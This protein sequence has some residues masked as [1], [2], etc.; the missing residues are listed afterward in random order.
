[1]RYGVEMGRTPLT[2]MLARFKKS[3]D[4]E[5]NSG[6]TTL[7]Q[8]GNLAYTTVAQGGG[9]QG[10][11]AGNYLSVVNGGRGINA[12]TIDVWIRPTDVTQGTVYGDW[13][14]TD[15]SKQVIRVYLNAGVISVD[16]RL[17][18]SS[19]KT[20]VS[21]TKIWPNRDTHVKVAFSWVNSSSSYIAIYLDGR[22]DNVTR[23]TGSLV[24]LANPV[25][26][27]LIGTLW[28]SGVA[29]AVSSYLYSGAIGEIRYNNDAYS[30][31]NLMLAEGDNPFGS[32]FEGISREKIAIVE[33]D[34]K[35]SL[36]CGTTAVTS[37]KWV[38][39]PNANEFSQPSPL[40]EAWTGDDASA[41]E[42]REILD[43]GRTFNTASP[44]PV[45]TSTRYGTYENIGGNTSAFKAS[46][47][48]TLGFAAS[49]G[50]TT[51]QAIQATFRK[52]YATTPT[53]F[54]D[55]FIE[56][57]IKDA[58]SITRQVS[59]VMKPESTGQVGDTVLFNSD[60][61]FDKYLREVF[62]TT[63]NQN[64]YT[65]V[66]FVN[67]RFRVK[68][69]GPQLALDSWKQVF[70]GI[71]ERPELTTDTLTI[72]ASEDRVDEFDGD[73]PVKVASLGSY[74]NVD[75]K[76]QDKHF[77]IAIGPGHKQITGL[78]IDKINRIV[79]FSDCGMLAI[80]NV[81]KNGSTTAIP[82]TGYTV[83]LPSGNITLT[84]SNWTAGA[85][86][87]A[88]VDGLPSSTPQPPDILYF[89]LRYYGGVTNKRID[90][91]FLVDDAGEPQAGVC[92][93]FLADQSTKS[94]TRDLFA[95]CRNQRLFFTYQ[96]GLG[97]WQCRKIRS[98]DTDPIEATF[99]DVDFIAY[100]PALIDDML[101]ATAEAYGLDYHNPPS[102]NV[103]VWNITYWNS[104]V[105]YGLSHKVTVCDQ[106]KPALSAYP[107][108]LQNLLLKLSPLGLESPVNTFEFTLPIKALD[109][110]PASRITLA[111]TRGID[112]NGA[113]TGTWRILSL[114]LDP[115]TWSVKG[116]AV[117]ESAF[118]ALGW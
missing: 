30:N 37:G 99:R 48:L 109:L 21:M 41:A 46:T 78:N 3:L 69:G 91:T 108:N 86:Y 43:V 79:N 22:L 66:V 40:Y 16:V 77:N 111:R 80:T 117:D 33:L 18:S 9:I 34:L 105:K 20:L 7:S 90:S 116:L 47:S 107:G 36:L 29:S 88:D 42:A 56:G 59:F 65:G 96:N 49:F 68:I 58:P 71:V 64:F 54:K 102:Q 101:C 92:H 19:T 76:D 17:P 23:F 73:I 70:E 113:G 6:T 100:K 103:S 10:F 85:T 8:T 84:A 11:G 75:T 83:D 72:K 32:D 82:T 57:R 28:T 53:V 106:S 26:R 50:P 5:D 27:P 98:A 94:L 13:D 89:W 60:G 87:T 14:T 81:R 114:T 61:F 115:K 55:Q 110:D 51:Y 2:T 67:A 31:A 35:E 12:L 63:P 4:S 44:A 38:A 24:N 112:A 93:M 52:R 95:A 118:P 62:L 74:P 15:T 25:Q 45:F 39:G 1:M 97:M 104:A